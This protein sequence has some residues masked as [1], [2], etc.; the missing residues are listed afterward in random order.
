MNETSLK[1]NLHPPV[2]MP[3][4]AMWTRDELAD[5]WT[6]EMILVILSHQ[7]LACFATYIVIDAWNTPSSVS[8]SLTTLILRFEFSGQMFLQSSC[9][10]YLTAN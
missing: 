8:M 10:I 2:E 4:N 6:K 5:I 1:W 3:P 9:P 7:V